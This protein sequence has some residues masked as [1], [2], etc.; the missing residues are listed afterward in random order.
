[1][2]EVGYPTKENPAVS[3]FTISLM[4][5]STCLAPTMVVHIY[6]VIMKRFEK[7]EE[8][9]FPLLNL[10][11]F[12]VIMFS[13]FYYVINSTIAF[14]QYPFLTVTFPFSVILLFL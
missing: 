8:I 7:N 12:F 2:K 5:I 3:A 4:I 10:V 14:K 13:A 6:R 1:L 11:P 9:F